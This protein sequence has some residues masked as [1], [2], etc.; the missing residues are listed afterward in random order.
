MVKPCFAR[1]FP[2]LQ[3]NDC[4]T[5]TLP[6]NHQEHSTIAS[7]GNLLKVLKVFNR[8]LLL[9]KGSQTVAITPAFTDYSE[10][11]GAHEC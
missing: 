8:P 4:S 3:M 5:C 1:E 2:A 11:S 7:L 9:K 6:S 10:N